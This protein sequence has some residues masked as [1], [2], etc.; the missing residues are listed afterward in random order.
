MA[1]SDGELFGINAVRPRSTLYGSPFRRL[2]FRNDGWARLIFDVCLR[3]MVQAAAQ[4]KYGVKPKLGKLAH[5]GRRCTQR[6]H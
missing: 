6:V 4:Q 2:S 5:D 1:I 3:F